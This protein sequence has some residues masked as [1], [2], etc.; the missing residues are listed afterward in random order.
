MAHC[1]E[2]LRAGRCALPRACGLFAGEDALDQFA[3]RRDETVGVERVPAETVGVMAGEHQ[4]V[5]QGCSSS[6][7]AWA[8]SCRVF[9][10]QKLRGSAFLPLSKVGGVLA[11]V[12]ETALAE[13]AHA[14]DLIGMDFLGFVMADEDQR[15]IRGAQRL[16]KALASSQSFTRA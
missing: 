7:A 10:M 1:T 16:G 11:P 13:A 14:V 5:V 12:R 3:H 4:V 15:G 9:W 2:G 8:M 6:G